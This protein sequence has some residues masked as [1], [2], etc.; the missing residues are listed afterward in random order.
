M[1][2]YTVCI[3]IETWITENTQKANMDIQIRGE[4]L[5]E[6]EKQRTF[7]GS[8]QGLVQCKDTKDGIWDY[9]HVSMCAEPQ[10]PEPHI[11]QSIMLF[12]HLQS[13]RLQYR[14]EIPRVGNA[15]YTWDM[16]SPGMLWASRW[17]SCPQH[18]HSRL[19]WVHCW[20]PTHHLWEVLHR[21][22]DVFFS[23]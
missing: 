11:H 3:Y 17:P 23:H 8:V 21:F 4:R 9:L 13:F 1:L 14:A 20:V 16:K 22:L 12:Q 15:T 10:D 5:L 18:K 2:F 7:L 6:A 19:P